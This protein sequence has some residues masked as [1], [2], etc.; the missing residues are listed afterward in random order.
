LIPLAIPN[1]A[2]NEGKYLAECV[3]TTFVSSVGPFVG[4]F[5]ED[6]AR[7]ANAK[8]AVASC[9]G[10]SALMLALIAAGILIYIRPAP[11][12]G[13]HVVFSAATQGFLDECN[14]CG[15]VPVGGLAKF[16][17]FSISFYRHDKLLE[18]VL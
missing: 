9:S 12:D 6:L 7:A 13:V 2:G 18:N 15:P 5:E 1:L 11:E 14:E 10:T 3:K 8:H 4:R 17:T 16:I